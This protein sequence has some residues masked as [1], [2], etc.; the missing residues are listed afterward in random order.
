MFFTILND[1]KA[2]TS[3][4]INSVAASPAHGPSTTTSQQNKSINRCYA[5]RCSPLPSHQ[6]ATKGNSLPPLMGNHKD[7]LL[8][9]QRTDPFCKHISKQLLNGKA[10][11]H[12]ADTFIHIN[13][14]LYKHAMDA[15]K[16]FLV[17]FI[18]KSWHFTVLSNHTIKLGHQGVNRTYH[19]IKWQYYWTGMNKDKGHLK[20]HC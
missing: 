9:M 14:L 5:T 17:L 1:H 11:H 10:P 2:A 13:D 12:E 18:D 3:I 19:L 20:I 6:D 15:T 8:Q 4:L 7:T 16:E